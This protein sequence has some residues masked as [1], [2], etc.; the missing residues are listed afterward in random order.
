[1]SEAEIPEVR[2]MGDQQRAEARVQ[3]SMKDPEHMKRWLNES[4][5][6]Y[7]IIKADELVDSLIWPFGHEAA[8][9]IFD[10][11]RHHRGT[12]STGRTRTEKDPITGE[13][14]EVPVMKGEQ[15]EPEEMVDVIRWLNATLSENDPQWSLEKI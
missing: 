7:I 10:A 11:I 5:R 9:Q 3:V 6:K 15:L 8:Q 4:G 1:M 14:V 13:S 12:I 2:K